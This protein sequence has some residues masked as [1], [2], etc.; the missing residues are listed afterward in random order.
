MKIITPV[1]AFALAAIPSAFA[2][3]V[4]EEPT[5]VAEGLK[6]TQRVETLEAD[7]IEIA[8]PAPFLQA[9]NLNS[10]QPTGMLQDENLTTPQPTPMLQEENLELAEEIK[11][12]ELNPE[13]AL[14]QIAARL[15]A[16]LDNAEQ[17]I[18]S[19]MESMPEVAD[20][21]AQLARDNGVENEVITTAA[22]LAGIDPTTIAE[23]TAAGISRIASISPPAVPSIGGNGGGGILVV[24]PN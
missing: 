7:N 17:I 6:V 3:T 15:S 22:L 16:D 20:Q 18:Q 5:V 10:A 4:Q 23:A 24:S 13:Q 9:K 2:T 19:A 11:I 14:P 21:I 8:K 1:V 12:Q